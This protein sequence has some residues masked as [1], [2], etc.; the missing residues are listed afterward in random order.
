M[1]YPGSCGSCRWRQS[2]LSLT[3]ALEVREFVDGGGAPSLKVATMSG[4]EDGSGDGMR[5]AAVVLRCLLRW[6]GNESG[7][8]LAV[9]R[10][11]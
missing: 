7:F 8:R 1:L 3:V 9:A 11:G 5:G 4:S 10:T 6:S 2:L